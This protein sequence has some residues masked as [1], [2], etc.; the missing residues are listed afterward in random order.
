MSGF[1][2]GFAWWCNANRGIDPADLLAGAAQIGFEGVDL[3]DEALWPLAKENGLTISAIGG[4]GTI[5]SGLN[6][7]ANADRIEAEL[8]E[9]LAKAEAWKIPNLVCFSGNR[10]TLS[11]AE[12]LEVCVSTLARVAPKAE[13]AGVTLIIELLNSKVDHLHY[14]CDHTAW[15]VQLCQQ[16]NSPAVRLLYDIYHM[17]VMEGDLIRTIQQNHEWF[18]YYH[19]AGNPGRH[20]HD[21]TQE[22]YYPPIYQAIRATNYAGWISHEFVPLGNPLE[23]LAVAFRDC[24]RAGSRDR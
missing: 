18:G 16:L 8:L 12:G 6:D 17:Q 2:Q 9:N 11:D 21:E 5:E 24:E 13:A 1:K 14:Q 7:P 4:H 22:I 23:E 10:G 3:L 15:G 19:T 20:L